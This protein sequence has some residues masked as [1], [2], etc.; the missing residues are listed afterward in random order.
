MQGQLAAMSCRDAVG[1]R[2][3]KPEAGG[4]V[5]VACVVAAHER[6]QHGGLVGVGYAGTVILDIDGHVPD[7]TLRR[8]VVSVPNFT[9]FSTTLVMLRRR[10]SGR[11]VAMA[12]SV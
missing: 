3:A 9:A 1:D 10:S 12:W 8:I 4:L 2:Q 7:K 5:H 11:T 6:L